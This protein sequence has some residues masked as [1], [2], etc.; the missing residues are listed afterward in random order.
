MSSPFNASLAEVDSLIS[1]AIDNEVRRQAGGLELIASENFVSEAVLEAMGSVFT[2][3]YAEGYPKKRYYGGCEWSDVVE[4]AAIDRAK[5]LFG[6]EHANV[7]PHSGAQANMAVYLAAIQYGDQILGMN[8]S[9]GGHLTH[10]HPM[11]FSG[12]S[13]KVA[14]YGVSRET[15][16]IDY[17]E[18]Q[19]I[20]E[21]HKPK[22][23]ICGASAYPRTIDFARIGEIAR[24]VGAKM[25]ADV[26]HIAGPIA[27]GLHPSPVPHADYVTTTT[28]KTLRGPRGG[29]ILC[30]EE[31]AAEINRK[32]FPGVQGGP[33]VHIIAAKAVA[34]GEALRDDFKEYQRNVL[35]NA[36]AL[37]AELAGQ[38]LR[39]VSGGTDNHLMLV[40]VFMGGKGITGK[41][42]EKALEAAN[43]TVNKNT[44]P[45]DTNKPFVTSGVR[46]GTPALTTRGMGED[47]MRIVGRLI[48]EVLHDPQSDET[49]KNVRHE[50]AELAGRFPL[51]AKRLKQR[52]A[53]PEAMSA[54]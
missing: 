20:A 40:D 26:A 1:E 10:G 7:Q 12:F 23:I 54:D 17:E 15:E 18:L 52:P 27:A 19:R 51:Y 25:F 43:I 3:K 44:I 11:N 38:G 4:Q 41:D 48:A 29:L 35:K 50:V 2:N 39:I 16:Q 36:K 28:H 9:H 21:E 13:Y 34:F 14:D 37:A 33:L 45:F 8:L 42:A 46:I 47:E 49:R 5:Q 53:K 6:A 22:L 32:V 31:Y 30:R 24:G